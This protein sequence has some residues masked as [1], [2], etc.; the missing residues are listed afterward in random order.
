MTPRLAELIAY[1][2]EHGIKGSYSVKHDPPWWRAR[3]TVGKVV[4]NVPADS[5]AAALERGAE[6]ALANL[7]DSPPAIGTGAYA[8][9]QQRRKRD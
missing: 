3:I 1:C 9:W 4:Y 5:R 7:T 8:A 6:V 2:R